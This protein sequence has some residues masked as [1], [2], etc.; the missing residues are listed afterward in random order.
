MT[1]VSR[2]ALPAFPLSPAIEYG[3]METLLSTMKTIYVEPTLSVWACTLSLAA[4][5]ATSTKYRY[6]SYSC[7]FLLF[8]SFPPFPSFLYFL[9]FLP[10]PPF[11]F[12]SFPSFLSL[13][14]PF[15]PFVAFLSFLNNAV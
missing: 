6:R 12:L 8:L 4:E 3:K 15:F 2:V 1:N 11:L 10:S 7:V 13:L 5:P 14:L 9:P